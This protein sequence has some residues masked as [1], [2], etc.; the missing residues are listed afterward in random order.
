MSNLIRRLRGAVAIA[1]LWGALFA[2]IA[3]VLAFVIGVVSPEQID[4]GE[5]AARVALIFGLA[6]FLSGL[7][8]A[9]LLYWSEQG[10]GIQELSLGRVALWGALGAAAVP[11]LLGADAGEGWITGT[12]GGLFAAGSVAI[13]RRGALRVDG[14]TAAFDAMPAP[15]TLPPG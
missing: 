7:G 3:A 13:A 1:S 14:Q 10:R 15:R 12:L 2:A 5:G 9:G 6:G 4:A 8:F 11:A